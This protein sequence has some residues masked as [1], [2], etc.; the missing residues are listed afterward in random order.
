MTI[1]L[2]R[3]ISCY[4]AVYGYLVIPRY[5][6]ILLYR[7][8]CR[9]CYTAVNDDFVIPRYN[10]DDPVIPRYMMILPYDSLY[11]EIELF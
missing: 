8:I 7:G 6:M 2:Y 9:S 5:M 11:R 4:S 1:V 10:Y 3:Y